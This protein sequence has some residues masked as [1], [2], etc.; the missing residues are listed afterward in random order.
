MDSVALRVFSLILFSVQLFAAESTVS[1]EPYLE[2]LREKHHLKPTMPDWNKPVDSVSSKNEE[3]RLPPQLTT[4]HLDALKEEAIEKKASERSTDQSYIE[5]LKKGHKLKPRFEREVRHG[6]HFA[7]GTTSSFNVKSDSNQSNAFESVY[8]TASKYNPGIL[9]GYEYQFYRSP[10]IGSF[11][12]FFESGAIWSNGYGRFTTL[13]TSN[14]D[15]KFRFMAFPLTVGGVYRFIQPKLIAPFAQMG[16]MA[17]PIMETRNDGRQS[18]RSLGR[19]YSAALG[20][21]LSLDWISRKDAWT[22]YDTNGILHSYLTFQLQRIQTIASSVQMT[23][24]GLYAGF[25]FE[26]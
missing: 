7:V 12:A 8:N 4:P 6:F 25:T 18:R 3:S 16:A 10:Y 11:G 15:V 1:Q 5:T 23:Y 26:Y 2:K 24:S 20:V 22:T 14:E 21:N 9:V 13:G 17:L 19:G